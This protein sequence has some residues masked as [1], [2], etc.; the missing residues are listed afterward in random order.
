[1]FKRSYVQKVLVQTV[2]CSEGSMFRSS[3][4]Q[5]LI[6]SECPLLKKEKQHK[7]RHKK[8][9]KAQN[10]EKKANSSCTRKG[11]CKRNKDLSKSRESTR[12]SLGHRE[13]R[14]GAK[15]QCK[16]GQGANHSAWHS[17]IYNAR[18]STIN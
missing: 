4:I 12:R 2:L 8:R 17:A 3:Y 10:H 14:H 1:M 9:H 18:H 16:K 6:C 5:K 13:I 15:T 7:Q 11:E